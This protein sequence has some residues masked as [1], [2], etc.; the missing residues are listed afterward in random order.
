MRRLALFAVFAATAS[1]FSGQAMAKATRTS[2]IAEL[3]YTSIGDPEEQWTSGNV[4][5]VRGQLNSGDV[6]GDLEGTASVL[7]NYNLNL[8][9]GVA[10]QWGTFVVATD[11]RTWEGVFHGKFTD[12][13][14]FGSFVGQGTDGSKISGDFT[15]TGEVA[16]VLQGT[17]LEPKP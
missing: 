7:A 8:L 16:F 2:F 3:M 14:N 9:T 1:L 17:I 6:T 11:E 4:F 12:T 5:H 15:Q 10:T 13:E